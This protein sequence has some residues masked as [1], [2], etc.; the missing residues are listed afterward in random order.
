MTMLRRI[1]LVLAILIFILFGFYTSG[2]NY[3]EENGSWL[4]STPFYYSVVLKL[5]DWTHPA[6]DFC[7]LLICWGLEDSTLVE[8]DLDNNGTLDTT[9]LIGRGNYFYLGG[10]SGGLLGPPFS[11]STRIWSSKPLS[12]TYYQGNNNYGWYDDMNTFY[13]LLFSSLWGKE[14]YV[15]LGGL[16]MNI[17][18]TESGAFVRLDSNNDGIFDDSATL[19]SGEVWRLSNPM[20]GNYVLSNEPVFVVVYKY[21]SDANDKWTYELPSVELLGTEYYTSE[22]PSNCG[23]LYLV[24]TVNGTTVQ[25][26]L[27]ADGVFDTTC[28]LDKGQPID[29]PPP[30]IQGT[31]IV[32]DKKI[33]VVYR[34][35]NYGLG[36]H[37]CYAYPLVAVNGALL[38][39]LAM[40]KF[41]KT[42]CDR[43]K[44]YFAS[45]DDD[46]TITVDYYDDGII[47]TSFTLSKGQTHLVGMESPMC[48]VTIE[49]SKPT[50]VVYKL[51]TGHTEEEEACDGHVLYQEEW[52]GGV[53]ICNAFLT[54]DKLNVMRSAEHS[55]KV[56]VYPCEPM[57]VSVGDT[58]EVYVDLDDNGNFDD[59]EDY[60]AT[61]SST[62]SDG[63][64]TDIA[65]KAYNVPLTEEIDPYVAI[66]S[67]NNIPIVDTAGNPIDYL[68][69]ITFSPHKSSTRSAIPDQVTLH[70]NYPNPFNPET[71]I[72]YSFP[73]ATHVRL[74]IYNIVGQKVRTLVDE[75]QQAGAKEVFWDGKDE[76][77]HQVGSGIYFY[78]IKTSEYS[79]TKKMILLR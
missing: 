8:F 79:E 77:G 13:P 43:D 73:E 72:K 1:E 6:N 57:D 54:P 58:A 22:T 71:I 59:Y 4:Q 68:Q 46:N 18:A 24:A 66:Y 62:D 44:F 55:F 5:P 53:E 29:F 39:K 35:D 45:F 28:Y 27:D 67:I 63:N 23:C 21:S 78:K 7:N 69:L 31:H 49:C 42:F 36:H 48:P 75:Y 32:S 26:D 30:I 60:L 20:A 16:G 41:Y 50:Q 64:A 76:Y 12:I 9:Y 3:A 19:G 15:P 17:G 25:L 47:D 38:K 10:G 34:R 65:V 52:I 74:S 51:R 40:K 56:H 11:D 61:V 2:K 70:Q 33:C 14:F 37:Q